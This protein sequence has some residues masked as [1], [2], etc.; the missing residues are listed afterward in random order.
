MIFEEVGTV[1][2]LSFVCCRCPKYTT[3][4]RARLGQRERV[5]G[6]DCKSKWNRRNYCVVMLR[7]TCGAENTE[8]LCHRTARRHGIHKLHNNYSLIQM[9]KAIVWF[10]DVP[11]EGSC[12]CCFFF[13][14]FLKYTWEINRPFT[15][16]YFVTLESLFLLKR[17]HFQ[18]EEKK[19]VLHFKFNNWY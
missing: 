14:T 10:P 16:I 4:K 5:E 1:G 18:K 11:L 19:S 15:M 7:P 3:R 17:L 12:C 6:L 9:N 2:F 8:V 13:T